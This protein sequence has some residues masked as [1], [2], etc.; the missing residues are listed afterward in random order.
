MN[1]KN[2]K[3][4]CLGVIVRAI[5]VAVL[6]IGGLFLGWCLF[7]DLAHARHKAVA[8]KSMLERA[9]LVLSKYRETHGRW[10]TT[11]D[12][13]ASQPGMPIAAGVDSIFNRPWLYYPNAKPGTKEVLAAAP[14]VIRMDWLPFIG[15]QDAVLADG[16]YV[17]FRSSAAIRAP[18]EIKE[19]TKR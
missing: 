15:W 17:D 8:E 7:W 12:E 18:A 9:Y 11:I 14:D 6:I 16:T 1:A 19:K 4:S 10:P 5:L 2:S 3:K 13:A